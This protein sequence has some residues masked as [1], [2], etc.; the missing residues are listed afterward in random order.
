V[1]AFV[2]A[3][4]LAGLGL[5]LGMRH[6]TD[7]DHVVAVTAIASRHRGLGAAA[8]VGVV[9]GLGHAL[10]LTVVGAAIVLLD[11]T[12]PP[13]LGLALEFSVGVALAIVGLLNVAGRG[14][15]LAATDQHLPTGRAFSIG[16]VHGTAGSAA[17]ALL[18]LATVRDPLAACL[19]LVVFGVGTIAGMVLVTIA[20]ASPIAAL[21]RR[22]QWS[23]TGLRLATGA[24]SLAFGL[25]VMAE[26][27][28]SAGLFAAHPVWTPR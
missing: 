20:F 17:V 5:A 10:T 3:L 11:L 1:T 19:Y 12:L 27:G 6:A 7:A 8:L 25:Y 16:L 26:T 4:P 21:A 18:V 24:L 9:W 28:W 22:F 2:E 13:R 23:G 14:G 15:F